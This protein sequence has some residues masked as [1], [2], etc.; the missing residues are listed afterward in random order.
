[1]KPESWI[2][3]WKAGHIGF[4]LSHTNP[5]LEKCWPQVAAPAGSTVFVPLCG[6]SLDLLWLRD[7]GYEVIGVEIS[8][9]AVKGFF[10]ENALQPQ[11]DHIENF[12]RWRCDGI[13]L[14][15]GDFF[16]LTPQMLVDVASVYDRASLIA[17]PETMRLEYV[18]KIAA[19][20]A[21]A[22]PTLLITL[23]Y[24][25]QQMSGPPF[26]VGSSEVESLYRQCFSISQIYSEQ[27]LDAEPHFRSKGLTSLIE[28]VYL[29]KPSVGSN[30]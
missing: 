27:I 21:P 17:L 4:H 23:E 25:Q 19:L 14:L 8:R 30:Q 3:R 7:Q 15:V 2:D 22:L 18:E 20:F 9:L 6:K 11:I 5:W 24:D 1:M 12:E 26:A 29:L 13:T 16:D 10:A 28:S